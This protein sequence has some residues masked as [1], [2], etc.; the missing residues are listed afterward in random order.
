MKPI[1]T[2]L[3][4]TCLI[5]SMTACT[6]QQKETPKPNR[7]PEALAMLQTLKTLP[8]QGV[9]MF[10]HHDDP[11]Y[12]IGWD[13]DEGRSDVKSVCGDYPAIMSATASIS[14]KYRST[15][16]AAKPWHNTN[17]AEWYRS[18]GTSTIR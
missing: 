18:A 10:G 17:E 4:G 9:F 11:V 3:A 2:I 1:H 16:S 15:A 12:G 14:T 7:T 8:Q 5:A 13:G 6:P